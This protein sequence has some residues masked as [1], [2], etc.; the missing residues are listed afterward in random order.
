MVVVETINMTYNF[1]CQCRLLGWRFG[2]R[3]DM[4]A[5]M[6]RAQAA[7][8]YDH[9]RRPGHGSPARTSTVQEQGGRDDEALG[10]T[11]EMLPERLA[12]R[13][14]LERLKTE[15]HFAQ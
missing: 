2:R 9:A 8:S 1:A 13:A 10:L 4:L 11:E 14:R 12:R 15:R 6:M 3:L 5:P 7:A